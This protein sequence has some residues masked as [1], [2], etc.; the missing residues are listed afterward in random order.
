MRRVEQ[1]AAVWISCLGKVI[2]CAEDIADTARIE[3][4]EDAEGLVACLLARSISTARAVVH[5]VGLGHV[6]EARML[7]RSMFENE[8][9]LE[10]LGSDAGNAF[11]NEMKEDEIFHHRGLGTAIEATGVEG[12]SR[13][14][15]I[16]ARSIQQNPKVKP[17]RPGQVASSG[18]MKNA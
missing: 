8:I 10:Q 5:L 1:D 14:R 9:Y 12:G 17:L 18:G 2:A 13:V 4:T 16:V 15:E 7:A 6:V 3:P 11:V